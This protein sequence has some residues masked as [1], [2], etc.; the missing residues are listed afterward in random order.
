MRETHE[1]IYSKIKETI[2]SPEPFIHFFT[3]IDLTV[4]TLKQ[5]ETDE[6]AL[7]QSFYG[8]FASSADNYN[9]ELGKLATSLNSLR[10]LNEFITELS[11]SVKNQ[12]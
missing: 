2:K 7:V 1:S 6:K 5:N 8:Q 11:V 10:K 3:D 4:K 12:Q 9:T